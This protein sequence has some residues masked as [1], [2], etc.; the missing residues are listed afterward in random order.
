MNER[1]PF[2]WRCS[3]R[4]SHHSF[5]DESTIIAVSDFFY[6]FSKSLAHMFS[7]ENLIHCCLRGAS[8]PLRHD[9]TP[10]WCMHSN[11]ACR[12]GSS[13]DFLRANR[14]P[15]A[16]P[17]S[18]FF[19]HSSSTLCLD[20]SRCALIVSDGVTAASVMLLTEYTPCVDSSHKL[21]VISSPR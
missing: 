6:S 17:C 16:G 5:T 13:V 10:S 11:P 14:T 4:R 7:A 15:H 9:W 8:P 20:M 19:C 18:S 21:Q 12:T 3:R 1:V 2:C